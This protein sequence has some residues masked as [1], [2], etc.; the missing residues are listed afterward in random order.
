MRL[1]AAVTGRRRE[2]RLMAQREQLAATQAHDFLKQIGNAI[3]D[4]V[5]VKDHEYRY[6]L[7]NQAFCN[8][9]GHPPAFFIGKTA[10]DALPQDEARRIQDT[11]ERVLSAGITCI[12]E[13]K[14]TDSDGIEHIV[15][16]KKTPY[17]DAHGN[18]F[19][20]GIISD[21]SERKQVERLLRAKE[22]EFSSL[23]TNLPVAV[24]RYDG[25]CRRRYLNP[26]A[27]KMLHG[28]QAELLGNVPGG[29]TVPATPAMIA[30]YRGKMEE[31]LA[32]DTA[33]E[34]DFVLDAL[35]P[36]RQEHYEVRFAPEHDTDGKIVS[37]LA[38]WHD[39][40]ERKRMEDAL[41]QSE[42]RCRE[43]SHLLESIFESPSRMSIY[44][45]DRNYRYLA[46]NN[47]FREAAKRGWNADI[48]IGMNMLEAIDTEG[49]REF[50]RQG[51]DHVLA[52]HSASL[53]S[54]EVRVTNE[55]TTH[56]TYH[57]NYGSPIRND[58]GQ[59]VGLTVFAVNITQR[60]QLEAELVAR[61]QEFRTL[62]KNAPEP[63]FRY[64]PD[65]RRIYVNAAI[66]R[67]SGIPASVLLGGAASDGKLIPP[68]EGAAIT[69]LVQRI[70]ETG[71]PGEIEVEHVGVDGQR[72]Y[73]HNRLAPECD[74]DGKVKSV[75]SI[76][77]D[78]T[79]H[80]LMEMVLTASEAKHRTI[81]KFANDGF[82]LHRIVER[83]GQ[84]E[85]ILHD[86]NHKGCE[87]W[88]HSHADILSGNFAMCNP[89]YNLEEATR[90]NLLAAAG[91]P[92]LFDWEIKRD[93]GSSTWGEVSL[94]RIEIGQESFL[95][96]V[97]RDVTDAKQAQQRLNKSHDI[98]R[99][100]AA[101][102]ETEREKERKELAHQIHED[103]AQNLAAIRLNIS[104]LELGGKLVATQ[105]PVL[106]TLYELTER[107]ITRIR[108]IVSVL[109]P[110]V[111]DLGLVS[112][113]H[114]LTD[115][116]KGFGF[117]F[118][119]ML[120]D[121]IELSDDTSIMLFRATQEILLNIALHA[122]ATHIDVALDN[123]A[124]TCRLVIRD[125]GCGFDPTQ[126]ARV[127]CFGL[128]GLAEQARH[129][130]GQLS[131]NTH[132]GQGTELL[133][134]LPVSMKEVCP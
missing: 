74:A 53:E 67:I 89:S 41:K 99:A 118:N 82:F 50:C 79:E 117:K 71:E 20:V 108:D 75:F 61:E 43:N 17:T 57:D 91:H 56:H 15:V 103:L 113:L 114:W 55:G 33:C 127:G 80:K 5:V 81:F 25:E 7:V 111:L 62:V 47:T 100:L 107:S 39:I 69:A 49:H 34:L 11:D 95:L 24:I 126:P 9:M 123:V 29:P 60:K 102:Q 112:A 119:L 104:W 90:R 92:Q 23:S 58:S 27:E 8:F 134:E 66:E 121:D 10:H 22:R 48:T 110:S 115:D 125:N 42:V 59:I 70:C 13:E 37:V 28:S 84:T 128:I 16:T 64:A 106:K 1:L 35:A 88:G 87:L 132:P 124:G 54:H 51:F 78:I 83:D 3:A 85:F 19:L 96:A 52:G 97:M 129:L 76:C 130:G 36:N 86:L 63:I 68:H 105:A 122:A 40:T 31:V 46:F 32:T 21:I 116:F 101:H 14:L 45:L 77:H 131:I 72:R 94:R 133:I 93:D 26:A 18:R 44:A 98:L 120:Q 6:V 65:G 2:Q 73:F 4:P 12:N 30:H 38:I 109:R